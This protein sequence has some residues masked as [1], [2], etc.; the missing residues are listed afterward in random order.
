MSTNWLSGFKSRDLSSWLKVMT[1]SCHD[2]WGGAPQEP[3]GA[4]F[5]CGVSRKFFFWSQDSY[6]QGYLH[7][8]RRENDQKNSYLDKDFENGDF[9]LKK[10]WLI[11]MTS[12]HD[13]VTKLSHGGPSRDQR[14]WLVMTEVTSHDYFSLNELKLLNWWPSVMTGHD[15]VTKGG[16]D[17]WSWRSWWLETSDFMIL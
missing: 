17:H 7:D 9:V 12:S 3:C 8:L 2:V 14:S 6:R 4:H 1:T 16:H 13:L 15:V 11:V 5:F 10:S